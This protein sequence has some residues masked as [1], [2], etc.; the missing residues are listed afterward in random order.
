[1]TT[2]SVE[3]SGNFAALTCERREQTGREEEQ[4]RQREGL[5]SVKTKAR[6][7]SGSGIEYVAT[8]V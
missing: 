3:A 8:A 7:G 1:M 2:S 4:E 5:Y 6:T